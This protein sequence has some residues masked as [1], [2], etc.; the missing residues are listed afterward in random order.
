MGLARPPLR[1]AAN[2]PPGDSGNF[3]RGLFNSGRGVG[4]LLAMNDPWA[5]VAHPDVCTPGDALADSEPFPQA[6]CLGRSRLSTP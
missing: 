4:R 1:G 5:P 3:R 6:T 2:R